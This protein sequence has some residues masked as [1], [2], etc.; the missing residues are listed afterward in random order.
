MGAAKTTTPRCSRCGSKRS[1]PRLVVAEHWVCERCMLELELGH[2][3]ELKRD[4]GGAPASEQ[5]ALVSGTFRAK[6]P[7]VEELYRRNRSDDAA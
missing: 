4:N 5:L 7:S 3:V 6:R 2:P 1:T